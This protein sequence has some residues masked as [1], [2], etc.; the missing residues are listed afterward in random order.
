MFAGQK[1]VETVCYDHWGPTLGIGATATCR[2]VG[3]ACGMLRDIWLMATDRAVWLTISRMFLS[4][5]FKIWQFA[6]GG[7][8]DVGFSYL[9]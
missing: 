2:A 5:S 6:S 4:C 3:S 9:K 7:S 8:L 1:H